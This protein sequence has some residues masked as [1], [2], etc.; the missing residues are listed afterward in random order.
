MPTKPTRIRY[1]NNRDH[2]GSFILYVNKIE[3]PGASVRVRY[4]VWGIPEASVVVAADPVLSRLGAE[5]RV[6]VEI[7]F[8]DD[9]LLA[10][11]G[12]EAVPRLLMEGEITGWGYQNTPSGRSISFT[13]VNQIA[14]FT[15][16]FIQF[17]SNVDDMAGAAVDI[18]DGV[19]KFSPTQ[20]ELVFPYSFFTQG[21]LGNS[22][23]KRPFDFIYNVVKAMIAADKPSGTTQTVFDG[24]VPKEQRAVP[25]A[26]FFARWAR[27][28]NFHNRFVAT[29]VFDETLADDAIFPILKQ[30]QATAALETLTRSLMGQVQN[31]G[32]IWDMLQVV[33]Q[34]LFEEVAMIPTA[35]LLSVNLKD[36]TI[37]QTDFTKHVVAD[38]GNKTLAAM[39]PDPQKPNRLANYFVKPQF[40]FGLP[41]ACN[42]IF[43]SMIEMYNYQENYATQATR[44]YFNDE[45]LNRL[46]NVQGQLDPAVL[47][48][49]ATSY[50]PE[51][52]GFQAAKAQN[53][54]STGKNFLLFPEEF[55]KGPV[56]DRRVLPTWLYFLKMAEQNVKGQRDQNPA[57]VPT[58]AAPQQPDEIPAATSPFKAIENTEPNVYALYAEYEYYRERYSRRQGAVILKFNPFIVPGFP[59]VVFDNRATRMDILC[60]VTSV[61]HTMAERSIQTTVSYTYGRTFQEMFDTLIKDF[62]EGST[63]FAV[64]PRDPIRDVRNVIQH[65]QSAEDFY[66]ALFF[67]RPAKPAKDAAMDWRKIVAYASETVD[68][69]PDPIVLDGTN[70][71]A[72]TAYD[73]A[74]IAYE[75][76]LNGTADGTLQGLT[77]NQAYLATVQATIQSA[78]ADIARLSALTQRTP[79]DDQQLSDAQK[80]LASAQAEKARVETVIAGIQLEMDRLTLVLDNPAV[81]NS[82]T[83][84]HNLSSTRELVPTRQF[85]EMFDSYDAA[86]QYAWRPICSLDEY[87]IFTGAQAENPIP[88]FGTPFSIGARYYERIGR[89]TPLTSDFHLPPGVDGTTVTVTTTTNDAT[90]VEQPDG[91]NAGAALPA[92]TIPGIDFATFPQTRAAWDDALLAYRNN[93]YI[94]K[95]PRG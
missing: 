3:I 43:P 80:T 74:V 65:F 23:I 56:M 25:A 86:M 50:P 94:A 61:E 1:S 20:S 38:S 63:A 93:V 5:D 36:S 82:L 2:N 59:A 49:L 48:A 12:D 55:Y 52:N 77:Q 11:S 90:N 44:L 21:L 51:A 66:Q 87:I 35:P 71:A 16:L 13:V 75:K 34:T 95:V 24:V 32:S 70:D 73:N 60:Y 45:V 8:I 4:G 47:N 78:Q 42:V 7:F 85:Q 81:K 27:L 64:G 29:P 68:G 31:A 14:V 37:Q 46:F 72:I 41:P 22:F 88:A 69:E 30:V 9:F 67:G 19:T 39:S 79:V 92:A 26:N 89:L 40:I 62:S 33:M 15:Q 17:L 54:K 10:R 28:T 53:L 57:F 18:S 6:Q 76:L 83:P 58:T 84:T 91:G